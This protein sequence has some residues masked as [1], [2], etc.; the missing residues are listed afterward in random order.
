MVEHVAHLVLGDHVG[1]V[2]VQELIHRFHGA[3]TDA[4]HGTLEAARECQVACVR[5]E[6]EKESEIKGVEWKVYGG[7][8]V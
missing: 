5:G 2:L 8:G 4:A 6:V 1:P 3:N 7:K